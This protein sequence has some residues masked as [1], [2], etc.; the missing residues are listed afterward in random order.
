MKTIAGLISL[1]DSKIA[2]FFDKIK[3][4]SPL[5][6]MIL[7]VVIFG[8]TAFAENNTDL[9]TVLPWFFDGVDDILRALAAIVLSPRTKRHMHEA[10]DGSA[11]VSVMS[12][13]HDD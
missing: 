5:I 13:D 11:G 3:T 12:V 1:F 6:Y 7:M 9:A 4:G 10:D 8:G 2:P